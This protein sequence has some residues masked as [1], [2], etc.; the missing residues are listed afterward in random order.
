MWV[1][2]KDT[3]DEVDSERLETALKKSGTQY[4]YFSK[5]FHIDGQYKGNTVNR[6][7]YGSLNNHWYFSCWNKGLDYFSYA[8]ALGNRVLNFMPYI[9]TFKLFTEYNSNCFYD[10]CFI[11]PLSPFKPFTGTALHYTQLEKFIYNCNLLEVKPEE[12]ILI[13]PVHSIHDEYRFV[14]A[15]QKVV[16]YSQYKDVLGPKITTN[17]SKSVIDYANKIASLYNPQKAYTLDV[18]MKSNG[19]YKVL[20]YGSVH[21][22]GLYACDMDKFVEAI[23]ECYFS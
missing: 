21:T 11:K 16:C 19:E 23:N 7:F 1:I 4:E 13:A 9:T 17:I 3:F 15:N 22:S 5:Y 18:C 2:E 10:Y 14:I 6:F 20:E 12:L 8:N